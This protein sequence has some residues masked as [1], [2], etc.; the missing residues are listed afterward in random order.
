MTGPRRVLVVG[1]GAREHALAWRLASEPGVETVAVAPGNAGMID[2]A[3][4]VPDVSATDTAAVVELVD[5]TEPDLVV[6]G[7]EAPLAGGIVDR[8]A[9]TG[10]TVFGPTRAAARLEASKSYC[11]QVAARAGIPMAAGDS[12]VE[13][14]AA[15]AFARRLGAPLVVKADGLAAGKGVTMCDTIEEAEAAIRGAL[16]H[17]AHG[18]AGRRVVV[19]QALDGTEL[20]LIA[21]CDGETAVGLPPARDY[22][23]LAEGDIGPNTGGMGAVSPVGGVGPESSEQLLDA[24]HRPALRELLNAG[25]PFRGALYA[26]LMLTVDGPRLL[27]FNVRFGDPETQAILPRLREPIGPLLL[28]AGS[29]RLAG[30]SG[31]ATAV[32]ADPDGVAVAV[33]LAASGYPGPPATGDPI[34]GTE[35]ARRRGALVFH[36]ATRIVSGRLVTAGGRVLTIVGQGETFDDARRAAYEAVKEV[37]FSGRQFRPDIGLPPALRG[38]LAHPAAQAGAVVAGHR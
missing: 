16:E 32:G 17:D 3:A 4:P 5:A 20:S 10:A 24:F 38:E 35:P 31:S 26:G 37:Q 8:L 33:V 36:G 28:A 29:G 34:A 23:R 27:E 6:V 15:L 13:V 9:V 2:V 19:E 21:I 14:Q 7:P 1:G 18:E 12:F 30:E 25:A 22:K 11:R